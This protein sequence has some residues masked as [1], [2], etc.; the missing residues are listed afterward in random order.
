VSSSAAKFA[1]SV[2]RFYDRHLGP[3]LFEPYAADLV[4][5]LPPVDGLRVLEIACGTGIV[6]RRL[7]EALSDS[8]IV[9]ATDLNE[10]MT[11]YAR[12]A[13]PA[14][15]I[16]WQQAD[17]QALAFDAG[18]F[19]V[20]VCQ[21]G[22]MFLPDKVQGFREARRVLSSDGV[23]L[24]NVWH[25]MEA[26]PAAGAIHASLAKLFPA[27]PP[28]FMET[29]YGYHDSERIRADMVEAGWK[30]VDLEDVCLQGLGPSAADFAAG[31]TLG[32]PLA[33]ELAERGADTDAVTRALTDALIPVGGKHP[34]KPALAAT[35]I[36]AVR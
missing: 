33:H 27:D 21:F 25:S 24:A 17:A 11:A 19:D 36:S 23:L 6:T 5:R 3:V 14:P 9:V 18:S 16:V 29:P 28:R 34:F 22:F 35:V 8:A 2:P 1:G 10:P 20:V 13:V 26:N 7:R 12:A 32:S 30:D 15:G 4:S 31:F